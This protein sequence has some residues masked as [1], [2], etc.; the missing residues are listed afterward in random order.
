[1][2]H[3]AQI[4]AAAQVIE[5]K[6]VSAYPACAPE[7]TSAGGTYAELKM[8]E[9]ITDGQLVTGPAW[10]AHPAFLAQFLKVVE[11]FKEQQFA[12]STVIA[13]ARNA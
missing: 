5:G 7:V 3:G 10:P 6:R 13:K 1:L 9:A 12:A 11:T 2:C 8:D 4:L